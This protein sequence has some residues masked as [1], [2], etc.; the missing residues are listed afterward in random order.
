MATQR[1]LQDT[2]HEPL[3]IVIIDINMAMLLAR[4][5]SNWQ[6][7]QYASQKMKG[8]GRD[9]AETFK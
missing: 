4:V 2:H 9:Y 3:C 1:L 6:Q 7:F 8:D 5:T